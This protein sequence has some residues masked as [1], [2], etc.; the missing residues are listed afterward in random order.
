MSKSANTTKLLGSGV[1]LALTSSLCCIGPLL[2][3][4]GAAGGA[5][6]MFN[7]IA[8]LRPYLLGATALVLALAFYQAYKPVKKDDCGCDT[9][10]GPMQSKTFL[11]VVAIISIGL[12]TYPYYEPYFQSDEKK[13]V[14]KNGINMHQVT[15]R[16]EGMTCVACEGHVNKALREQK[17]VQEVSTSYVE[18]QS[19]V[20]YDRT[21]NSEQ[22]LAKII[23][24][25]TGYK[26]INITSDVN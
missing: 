22:Q 4:F 19:R 12:S 11:W 1:I 8:P 25:Q 2:A 7:W 17:G 10:K 24:N 16:I 20:K 15:F 5:L 3:I 6:T 9:K 21:K 13:V 14:L 23:E 18:G 26:V